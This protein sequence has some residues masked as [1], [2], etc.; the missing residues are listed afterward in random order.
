MAGPRRVRHDEAA[1]T[2]PFK[3]FWTHF[4]PDYDAGTITLKPEFFAEVNDGRVELTFHFWSGTRIT[5]FITKTGTSVT[6]SP[7]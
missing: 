1:W 7:A 4:Q 3:E 6:G 2:T 5:Y